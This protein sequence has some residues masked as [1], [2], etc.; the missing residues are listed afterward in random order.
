MEKHKYIVTIKALISILQ[1]TLKANWS[2]HAAV[3]GNPH[4]REREG[5]APR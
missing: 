3:I 5:T 1:H 4:E 2:R